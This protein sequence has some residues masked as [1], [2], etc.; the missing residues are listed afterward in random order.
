MSDA[1]RQVTD[2]CVDALA[3]LERDGDVTGLAELFADDRA[4]ATR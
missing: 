4:S 1:V 2:Q 3:Q